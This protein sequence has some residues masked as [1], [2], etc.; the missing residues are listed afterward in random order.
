GDL[1]TA[2]LL[3][4]ARGLDE[5]GVRRVSEL[6]KRRDVVDV[7][8]E[9]GRPAQHVDAGVRAHLQVTPTGATFLHHQAANQRSNF[10]RVLFDLELVLAYAHAAALG[11][12][13]P[14][15]HEDTSAILEVRLGVLDRL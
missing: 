1:L 6:P 15:T 14:V 8:A 10:A 7:H 11:L 12:G 9:A 5:V 13:A 3:D 4:D 2:G